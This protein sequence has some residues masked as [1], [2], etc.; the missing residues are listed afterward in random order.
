MGKIL[1]A[2]QD[3]V[4]VL[5]FVGDVRLTLGPT[6]SSF[7]EHLKKD[8]NFKSMIVDVSAA[9]TIDSTSLGL[10]AKVAISTREKFDSPTTIVSP[11]EDI[12]RVLESMAMEEVCMISREEPSLTPE[13]TELPQEIAADDVLREQVLDAHKVLM[14]LSDENCDKFRDLVDALENERDADNPRRAAGHL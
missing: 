14:G 12:T 13:L 6:I 10:I 1:Y 9:D 5:K 11:N 7:L 2:N 8:D 3:G 4:H